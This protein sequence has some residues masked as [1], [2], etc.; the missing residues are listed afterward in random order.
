MIP[1]LT[2]IMVNPIAIA[3]GVSRTIYNVIPQWSKLL[4]GLFF[5]FWVLAHLYPFAK[6]LM[7]RNTDDRLPVVGVHRHHYLTAAGGHQSS[8]GEL[9]D[10]RII[11]VP[12]T[13]SLHSRAV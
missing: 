7:G 10:R 12:L 2:I 13:R 5:S 4:G 1:P 9:A 11:H 3:V 8:V 6:G